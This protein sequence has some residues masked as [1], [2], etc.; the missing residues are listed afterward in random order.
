MHSINWRP[1]KDFHDW[2]MR[3]KEQVP[4]N[5]RTTCTWLGMTTQE[6]SR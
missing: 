2:T 6:S 3:A 4:F 5:S 1:V